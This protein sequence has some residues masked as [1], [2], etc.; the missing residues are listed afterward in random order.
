MTNKALMDARMNAI[1][2][3]STLK[4]RTIYIYFEHSLLDS[5]SY[6]CILLKGWHYDESD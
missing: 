4:G 6:I 2:S 3:M 1:N 5:F